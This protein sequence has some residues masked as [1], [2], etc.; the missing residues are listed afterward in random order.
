MNH[1]LGAPANLFQAQVKSGFSS[2]TNC[3]QIHLSSACPATPH[4]FII[5]DNTPVASPSSTPSPPDPSPENPPFPQ[6][7]SCC[8]GAP[9][10]LLPPVQ[11]SAVVHQLATDP[12]DFLRNCPPINQLNLVG[13]SEIAPH[14]SLCECISSE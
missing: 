3:E 9:N 2:T 5:I 1:L 6:N 4:L 12:H 11:G 8:L 14:H 10:L 7:P 13:A